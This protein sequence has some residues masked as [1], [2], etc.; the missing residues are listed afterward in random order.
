[1]TPQCRMIVAAICDAVKETKQ[2]QAQTV[3]ERTSAGI[4]VF[5]SKKGT[6]N[7]TIRVPVGRSSYAATGDLDDQRTH[8]RRW[9][10]KVQGCNHH[11]GHENASDTARTA[12]DRY[13]A[14]HALCTR[15]S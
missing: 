1:M 9:R 10:T 7:P 15:R 5:L 6:I 11:V 3:D 13:R 12:T 2:N 8:G 4:S 14:R